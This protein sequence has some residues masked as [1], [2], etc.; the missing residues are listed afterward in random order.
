MGKVWEVEEVVIGISF[1]E[2]GR[3][4][5]ESWVILV[6]IVVIRIDKILVVECYFSNMFVV[7]FLS[8]LLGY[9]RNLKLYLEIR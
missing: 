2:R 4:I 7:F 8:R 5:V 1:D 3:G 9:I 6:L